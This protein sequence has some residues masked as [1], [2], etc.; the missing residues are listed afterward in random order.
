[1]H[2]HIFI[3]LKMLLNENNTF[4]IVL[5]CNSPTQYLQQPYLTYYKINFLSY[6]KRIANL[7]VFR[8]KVSPAFYDVPLVDCLYI[9][10]VYFSLNKNFKYESKPTHELKHTTNFIGLKE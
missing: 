8:R 7:H 4:T 9:C 5:C 10:N 2:V 3:K 1:M 6:R